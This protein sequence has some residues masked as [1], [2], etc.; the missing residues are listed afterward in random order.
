MT[1]YIDPRLKAIPHTWAA[2]ST[3]RAH[4]VARPHITKKEL[5]M[6]TEIHLGLGRLNLAIRHDPMWALSD[7][8]IPALPRLRPRMVNALENVA[9]EIAFVV[10]LEDDD[11]FNIALDFLYDEL[12]I[13]LSGGEVCGDD[14]EFFPSDEGFNR[15]QEAVEAGVFEDESAWSRGPRELALCMFLQV[16]RR[17]MEI[18]TGRRA[19]VTSFDSET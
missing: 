19:V 17:A 9:Y 16:I 6:N 12:E 7:P 5:I 11:T 13:L 4:E 15:L 2:S 8:D 10:G 14:R 3:P 18:K 1:K